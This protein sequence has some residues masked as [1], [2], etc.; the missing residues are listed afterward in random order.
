MIDAHDQEQR[1]SSSDHRSAT[2]PWEL[3]AAILIACLVVFNEVLPLIFGTGKRAIWDWAFTYV[4]LRAIVIPVVSLA[5]LTSSI[6]RLPSSRGWTAWMRV[7]SAVVAGGAIYASWIYQ[8]P[9][10]AR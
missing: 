1:P 9:L 10:F 3:G 7:G 5:V 6:V 4:T 8:M 2:R